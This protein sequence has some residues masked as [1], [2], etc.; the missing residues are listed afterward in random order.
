M[1]ALA[2]HQT[3]VEAAAALQV[4]CASLFIGLCAQIK[5]PLFFTPVPISG[6]TL[7]TLLVGA[8]L[9]S[10]RGALAALLYLAEGAIGLPVWAG[11][12]FGALCLLGPTGGYLLSY[13]LQVYFVGKFVEKKEKPGFVITF[14]ALFVLCSLQLGIGTAWLANFVPENRVLMLGFTPFIPGEMLKS[15]LVATWIKQRREP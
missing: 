8:S 5:I 3:K 13:P 4:L 15:L 7:A 6:Q 10:K 14:G 1:K 2:I 11:G 9:G 12:A